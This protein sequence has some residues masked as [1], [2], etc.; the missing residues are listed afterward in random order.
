VSNEDFI[1]KVT[2]A[3]ATAQSKGHVQVGFPSTIDDSTGFKPLS[4][5]GYEQVI[6][7]KKKLEGRFEAP[8]NGV[9]SNRFAVS[10]QTYQQLLNSG[11]RGARKLHSR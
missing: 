7:C 1:A 9:F 2:K 6:S 11:N 5:D 4:A 3:C 8:D 10:A